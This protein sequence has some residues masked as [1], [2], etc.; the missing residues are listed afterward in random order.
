MIRLLRQFLRPYRRALVLV[1]ALLFVQA[2]ANLYLPTLNAEIINRGVVTGDI[3]VILRIGALM[4]VVTLALGV[5]SIIAVYYSAR[6]S[7]RFGR[8]VRAAMFTTVERFSLREV[9]EFGTPSLITR[10]TN[11]VQQVQMLVLMGLPC[12]WSRPSLPSVA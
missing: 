2:I 1:V 7:M 6:T 10:N 8:D 5:T 11:D 4:L 9:D 3:P 12:W